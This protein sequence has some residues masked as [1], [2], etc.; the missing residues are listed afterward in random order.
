M[1]DKIILESERKQ[2]TWIG[3]SQGTSQM[4]AALSTNE[5]KIADKVDLFV[6]LAPI[7]RMKDVK[8][9]ALSLFKQIMCLYLNQ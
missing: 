2:V 9:V 8:D 1:I 7:P 5:D 6:A 3:H 4:F